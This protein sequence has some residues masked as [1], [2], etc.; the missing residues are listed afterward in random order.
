[1]AMFFMRLFSVKII[2]KTC[3]APGCVCGE[4]RSSSKV[5]FI[6]E[7]FLCQNDMKALF[8]NRYDGSLVQNDGF[9]A[10]MRGYE[11]RFGT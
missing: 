9:T 11:E 8:Y 1:M 10:V 7:Y 5:D 2:S 4:C 3:V 6:L